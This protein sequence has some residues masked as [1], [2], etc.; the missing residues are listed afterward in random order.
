MPISYCF[1]EKSIF[2]FVVFHYFFCGVDGFEKRK[3]DLWVVTRCGS[4]CILFLW[5]LCFTIYTHRKKKNYN[6]SSNNWIDKS[7]FGNCFFSLS[8]V[9]KN[10][11]LFL[12]LKNLFGNSK[13]IENK[14]LFHM[15][16]VSNFQKSTKTRI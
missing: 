5:F 2:A 10:N 8:Y 9:S 11:F 15:F 14:N 7:M 16:S 3:G 6:I 1:L 13:G 12:R 4:L